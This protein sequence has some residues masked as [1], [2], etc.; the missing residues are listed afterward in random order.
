MLPVER[1]QATELK[2]LRLAAKDKL[3]QLERS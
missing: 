3:T 1:V 2:K